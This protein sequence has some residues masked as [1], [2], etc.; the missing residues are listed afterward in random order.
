MKLIV[1]F[2]V[3]SFYFAIILNRSAILSLLSRDSYPNLF[4]Y[5]VCVLYD[6]AAIS[7]Q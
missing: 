1:T 7:I 2:C 6:A 3:F 5:I 4:T